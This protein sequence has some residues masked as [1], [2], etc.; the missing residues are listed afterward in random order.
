MKNKFRDTTHVRIK[1]QTKLLIEK[2]KGKK[3]TFD[4]LIKK[5]M[6]R[7]EIV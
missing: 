2:N 6:N 1:K 3:E 4:E 7:K 5:L